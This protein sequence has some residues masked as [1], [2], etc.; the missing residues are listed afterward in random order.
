MLRFFACSCDFLFRRFLM[1]SPLTLL[2]AFDVSAN[3]L[4]HCTAE[5]ANAFFANIKHK[6]GV[7][8]VKVVDAKA[9]LVG[10]SLLRSFYNR[11]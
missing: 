6:T 9:F 3:A 11:A 5:R 10:F 4:L 2:Y 8:R 1:N 7:N